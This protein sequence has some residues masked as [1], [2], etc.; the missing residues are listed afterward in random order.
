[1]AFLKT[2][3]PGDVVKEKRT[4]ASHVRDS[5]IAQFL[6]SRRCP[7]RGGCGSFCTVRGLSARLS[8]VTSLAPSAQ[9]A[10]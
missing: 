5:A 9:L 1:M 4:S 6:D 2:R 10:S 8:T 3:A 7:C